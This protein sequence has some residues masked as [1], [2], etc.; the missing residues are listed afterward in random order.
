MRKY[1]RCLFFF[2]LCFPFTVAAQITGSA[3]VLLGVPIG[4]LSPRVGILL[5]GRWG[6]IPLGVN[7]A[8]YTPAV[9]DVGSIDLTRY[10]AGL[11]LL[12]ITNEEGHQMR[13]EWIKMH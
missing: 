10:A 12:S 6:T 1:V 4:F 2:L 8:R 5:A 7:P 9:R 13:N 11:Y 3:T